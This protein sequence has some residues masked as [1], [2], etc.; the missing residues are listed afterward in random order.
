MNSAGRACYVLRNQWMVDDSDF[1]IFH[2][3]ENNS[4]KKSGTMQAYEYAKGVK[5]EIK[6][7][8]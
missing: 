3:D 8:L 5:V 2:F 4:T 7:I 6:N 1:A